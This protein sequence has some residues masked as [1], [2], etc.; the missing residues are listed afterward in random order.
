MER[1]GSAPDRAG[2][3]GDAAG[4]RH[5]HGR[6]WRRNARH[7]ADDTDRAYG[8]SK[9]SADHCPQDPRLAGLTAAGLVMIGLPPTGLVIGLAPRELEPVARML[10]VA[11][12][13]RRQ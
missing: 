9:R 7:A 12:L 4:W 10:Q 6:P 13:V 11:A 5:R 3:P 1:P 8:P 2:C